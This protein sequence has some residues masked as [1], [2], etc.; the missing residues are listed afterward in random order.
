MYLVIGLGNPGQHYTKNRHNI[1][2]RLVDYLSD[3]YNISLKRNECRSA[4]GRGNIGDDEV[5]LAKPKTY[6]NNSGVA[7]SRLLQK[8]S[9]SPAQFIVVYDDLD[10]PLG[11]MRLRSRGSAGGHKG[12][13]SIIGEIGTSDF[14]RIKIG[15]GRPDTGKP[16]R[17]LEEEIVNYVLSDFTTVE[18]EKVKT[19]IATAAD[20]LQNLLQEGIQSA[21]NKFNK[22]SGQI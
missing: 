18:E 20:A 5:M 3:K 22:S 17:A 19:V 8:F 15:I 10:L 6:M 21:M 2:F 14:K 1:G 7:V 12:I 16:E 13:K 4:V 11:Q 9:I